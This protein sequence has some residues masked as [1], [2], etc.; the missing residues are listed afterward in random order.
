MAIDTSL[1]VPAGHL[2]EYLKADEALE[3]ILLERFLRQAQ[4]V[5]ESRTHRVFKV[6]TDDIRRFDTDKDVE[7]LTLWFFEHDLCQISTVVNGDGTTISNTNY[8][9]EPRNRT[10]WYGLTLKLGSSLAWTY[11]DSPENAISITGRWGY[12]LTP[13]NDIIQATLRLGAFFY[14]QRD[15]SSDFDRL[16]V[17]VSGV[18]MIPGTL[19]MDVREI[20]TPY[21]R[22]A[23]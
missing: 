3:D 9:T 10:P 17:S 15:T 4:K 14:R 13:P 6:I 11:S 5:I 21:E 8:V 20:L 18:S 2:R 16:T 1:Y 22:R 12:S 19:P 7:G 23:L